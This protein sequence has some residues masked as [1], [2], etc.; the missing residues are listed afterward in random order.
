MFQ[1]YYD[2]IIHSQIPN[3]EY[4]KG[5]V[6]DLRL[7]SFHDEHLIDGIPFYWYEIISGGLVVG[8][9]SLRLGYN[10]TTLVNGH[11]GYEIN[12][13]FRGHNY[14]YYALEMIKTL[15]VDHGFRYLLLSATIDN[16]FS[17][18]TIMKS[19]GKLLISD[20]EVPK[21]HIFYVLGKPRMN[22]YEIM[23]G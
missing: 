21:D 9:I 22:V 20:Y 3:K 19:G 5:P 15:A 17:Q 8:K 7:M 11:V 10:D 1:H 6:V 18:Q 12:E 14:S 23:L 16:I 13:D 4:L 2:C